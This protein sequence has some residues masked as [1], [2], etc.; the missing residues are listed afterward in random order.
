MDCVGPLPKTKSGNQ[1][2]LTIMCIATRYPEAIPL[3]KITSQS[4]VKALIKFFSTFGLPKIVQTDQGTN[5]LSGIFEQVLQSLSINHRI[6]SAYHPESQG[7]L[8]R[9]HQTF[10]SVLRKYCLE[11]GRDWDDGVPL[12]L[13]AVRETVQES[14]GFSPAELVFGHEVRGPLKVL[15][16]QF[17]SESSVSKKANVL[18]YVSRFRERL[19]EACSIAKESLLSSQARM[20]RL[21]DGDA[22]PRSLQ[23]G[24]KVLV[25]LPVTGSSLSARFTGPYSV[26]KKLSETDYVVRTPDRR[27]QS[28]VCHINMLKRYYSRGE[29]QP[30]T[31]SA[32]PVATVA[33][34]TPIPVVPVSLTKPVFDEDGLNLRNA[35]QQTPRLNNS[36]MLVNLPSLL[37]HLSRD[38]TR[39]ILQVVRDC[40]CLFG[41]VPTRT[42]VLEHDID[43]S[44]AVP[45]KQHPYRINA[46]KRSIM[47]QEIL[48]LLEHNL[49][50]PSSSPWSSPC[51]LVPKPDSTFRFC[52]D[53]R[54]VNSVTIPD[55]Y[56]MPRLDDCVD[57]IG[58]ARYVTKLDLLKGYWQVPLTP[59]A[60]DI[61]AFVTPDSFFYST[62][63]WR[64]EC[65]M[66]RLR[67]NVW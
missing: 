42:T 52:T 28:R 6:S 22:V 31:Q 39:D 34:V 25:L 5:F 43:V 18:A 62:L 66:H 15:K 41:D 36:E 17:L 56:P 14:L 54:K 35:P 20:K 23:P 37:P 67:F 48:Y 26:E 19:R 45:I 51:I 13:F 44:G 10:K 53:Y 50:R 61:S 47:K 55:S 57:T 27:R 38:Q 33:P 30:N 7:A 21:F 58:S 46:V 29:T 59:R 4:V 2:L 32:T 9:W 24:D 11:T 40:S 1:F 49:A 63:S 16:E 3:R 8:E 64:L 65:V 60:S 12:A